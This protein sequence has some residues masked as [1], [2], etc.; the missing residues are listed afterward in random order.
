MSRKKGF[1][2]SSLWSLSLLAVLAGCG[3][4]AAS[5]SNTSAAGTATNAA[6]GD[7]EKEPVVLKLTTWNPISQTVVD[8]FQEK[9]PYI[10]IE[11]DKV[12]DQFREII[13]TRIVSKSD[14]DMLW[15][16]PNQVAEFSKEDVLMDITGSPWLDN[17][18][19]AAVKLG[20][21]DGKTYGVPY[22]SQPIVMFYNKTLF[23]ELGLEIPKTWDE[24]LAVS[25]QIKAS[26]TAPMVI[27]SK[28]GW[29]TQFI[30]TSQFGLYQHDNP[31]VFAQLASGE[32][33]WT[34]PEFSTY[35]DGMKELADKGYLLE[36]SVGL[37]YDQVAQVFKEGKA[38]M[39]PMG[40]W[41]YSENFDADFSAFELGAFPIPVNR[42][43]QPLVTNLVS[44]NL[45]VGVSWS[46][47]Q[48]EIK[49]FMEFVADP[50]IAKIWSD[51]TKQ[52]V[53]VKGGTSETYSPLAS[54]LQPLVDASEAQIFPSM[55]SSIEPVMFPI[56]QQILLKQDV[57]TAKLLEQMQAAQDKDI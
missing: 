23:G 49:L 51:E 24:L 16:F 37:S 44:D 12:Y 40:E 29:A 10:T 26:G 31:D 48:E 35:F 47:H 50:E 56:F 33:K 21:V 13:R 39:W 1:W 32:K 22:N 55:T 15:L 43:D 34:D 20:T 36:N 4:N 46:K 42:G 30:T 14:M 53:T 45:L 54:S 52:A 7:A 9:Y 6:G 8:K 3:S 27:G 11:H 25:E 17:Y 38:A 41:G 19:E 28:D 18:L 2:R 5:D 57:D